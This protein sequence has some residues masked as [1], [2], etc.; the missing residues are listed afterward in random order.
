MYFQIIDNNKKCLKM[1]ALDDYMDYR[2]VPNLNKT[3]KHSEHLS[4]RDDVDYAY[5]YS[6]DGEVG[7]ICPMFILDSWKK[8]SGKISAIM[9]SVVTSKCNVED[10]CIYDYIPPEILT[11]FLKDKENI[12]RYVFSSVEKPPHYDILKKA[13]VLTEEMN[14]KSNLYNG[15]RKNTNYSIFGTRTGRLSNKKSGIPILTMK[16][17]ERK[18]LEP[19]NDLFVEF[20]FNA[21]ELRTLLALSNKEQPANDIHEWNMQQVGMEI[22]RDEMKKRT[23]A[24]LYNPEA[25]DPLLERL[26][27]R[28]WVKDNYR[29]KQG[30]KTPFLRYIETDE[31]RSLN[32]IVQSTSSDVCIEQAYKLREFFKRSRTK[33]CYLLH[34]SVI[35]D[36]A[37]EDVSKF[38]EAKRIFGETRFGNYVVNSSIGKNFGEMKEV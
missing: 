9:K 14:A 38:M 6:P 25:R 2:L 10:Y 29:Y 5:L 32:Y 37:K 26:Y 16:K 12:M 30:I 7:S 22:T 34:D 8:T 21:A 20:D 1:Y 17:E 11:A 23:F 28:D 35:L 24:W 19:S 3:W 13:H 31:R 15:Q 18:S 36:F 4:E 27:S 33:I